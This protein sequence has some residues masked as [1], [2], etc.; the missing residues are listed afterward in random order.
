MKLQSFEIL[1]AAPDRAGVRYLVA[2]VGGGRPRVPSIHEG[3]AKKACTSEV[4]DNDRQQLAD[5]CRR[6]AVRRLQL[7]GSAVAQR[8]DAARSDLDFIVEFDPNEAN[9]LFHRYFGLNEALG[10]LFGRKVDVVM[11][12]AMR[13][14]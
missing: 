6:F 7:F 1:A 10:N 9:D 3:S 13:N 14:P 12:G 8:F 2:G 5:L 11:A 4:I